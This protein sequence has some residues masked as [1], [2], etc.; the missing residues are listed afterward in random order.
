MEILLNT[1]KLIAFHFVFRHQIGLRELEMLRK[2]NNADL[3][4]KMHCVRLLSHFFH[5]RHLCLVLEPLSMNLR[6]VLKKY[7]GGC[8]LNVKAVRSYSQQLLFALKLLKKA[9]IL[10][11]GIVFFSQIIFA[12]VN[13]F[14]L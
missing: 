3:S 7:G 4:D 6:E 8:G 12:N 14:T 11:A 9:A 2:L 5:R 1:M 13:E 10:H